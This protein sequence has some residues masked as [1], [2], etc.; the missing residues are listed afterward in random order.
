MTRVVGCS[1]DVMD[2]GRRYKSEKAFLEN[3][4]PKLKLYTVTAGT[5]V[6]LDRCNIESDKRFQFA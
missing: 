2:V 4:N 3:D 1:F 5:A 6:K